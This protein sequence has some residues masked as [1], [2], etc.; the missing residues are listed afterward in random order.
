MEV[1][2]I[3]MEQQCITVSSMGISVTQVWVQIASGLDKGF[4]LA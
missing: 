3:P 4:N 1:P 2:N